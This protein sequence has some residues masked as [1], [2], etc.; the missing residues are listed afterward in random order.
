MKKG[1]NYDTGFLPE[2][3]TSR[4]AFD[5]ETVRREMRVIADELHCT[6]VRVSG[7]DPGRLSVAAE[8]AAAA[9]MEVYFAPFPVD[10]TPEAALDLYAD[11]ADRAQAVD[12]EVVLVTGC[13]TSAFCQGFIPGLTY[14]D[15]LQ[16]MATADV[17]W[18]QSLGPTQ[19]RLN[20]F[21]AE[22]ADTVRPRFRGRVTYA[23][24]PWES[25]D[26]SP[27]DLVGVDAYRAAYNAETF[28][29]EIRAH[30]QHGKPVVVTEFGTCAY[31]G[32]GRLGGMAWQP[33]EGAVPDEQ[34]QVRYLT[35]LVDIFEA[36]GVDTALWF[37]FAGYTRLG[38]ADLGSYGVVRMLD[39]TRWEP[40][41][42]FHAMA[43]RYK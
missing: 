4:R 21:L 39:E 5:P 41:A 12:G 19:Q 31:Q 11:C 37:T 26:W 29:E 43:G 33:P 42:V 7:G 34:E 32:A 14:G 6:A 24:G 15:R 35:E 16:A 2:P 20:D 30:R 1:I 13:E 38:A 3:G 8:Q 27:F 9:G 23:S 17:T 28:R 25:I 18:W 22:A 40:K 10:L 36:E